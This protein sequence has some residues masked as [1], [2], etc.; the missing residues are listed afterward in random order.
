MPLLHDHEINFSIKVRMNPQRN[1]W[2]SNQCA[3]NFDA[4]VREGSILNPSV[5]IHAFNSLQVYGMRLLPAL[6]LTLFIAGCGNSNADL[7]EL[8]VATQI[9]VKGSLKHPSGAKFPEL[10]EVKV[11]DKTETIKWYRND[12]ISVLSSD[13]STGGTINGYCYA[14]NG[15]GAYTTHKFEAVMSKSKDGKWRADVP[16]QVFGEE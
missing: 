8:Y 11:S 7:Q 4:A 1:I 5:V 12:S 2:R 9:E 6:L 16:V 14:Q 13:P 10:G 3:A 15:F